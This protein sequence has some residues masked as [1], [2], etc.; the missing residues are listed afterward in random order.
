MTTEAHLF[1]V[2]HASPEH[3][4]YDEDPGIHPEISLT[5]IYRAAFVIN[6]ILDEEGKEKL[7]ILS[8]PKR[9]AV[10]TAEALAN[11]QE[12]ADFVVGIPVISSDLDEKAFD[13]MSQY[14]ASLKWLPVMSRL[15]DT[16]MEL[17]SEAESTS[18]LL[19][20]HEPVIRTMRSYLQRPNLDPLGVNEFKTIVIES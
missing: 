7:V 11:S 4:R 17:T 20:T 10:E 14:D 15:V 1:A 6:D 3:R 2:R 8:S 13:G 19:V 5:Q 18:L 16:A 9:R 12:L